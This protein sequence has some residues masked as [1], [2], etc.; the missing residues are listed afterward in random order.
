[1][2]KEQDLDFNPMIPY[3][4]N[5][6][7]DKE[8]IIRPG[9]TKVIGIEL[10]KEFILQNKT[11]LNDQGYFFYELINETKPLQLKSTH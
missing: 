3:N 5:S 10:V 4:G 9:I 6:F 1:M 7:V 8:Q 11:L 2:T